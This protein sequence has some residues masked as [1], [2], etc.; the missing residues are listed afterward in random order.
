MDVQ[1]RLKT[2]LSSLSSHILEDAVETE[3]ISRGA[4]SSDVTIRWQG[5]ELS[6]KKLHDLPL[7]LEKKKGEDILSRLKKHCELLTELQHPN[8]VHYIGLTLSPNDAAPIL[9]N[10]YLPASVA[11]LLKS[12][13]RFPFDVQL[14]I[15]RDVSQGLTFLHCR[16]RPIVHANLNSDVVLLTRGLQAKISDLGVAAI[17]EAPS[18]SSKLTVSLSK[19]PEL[20]AFLPPDDGGKEPTFVTPS[21][22]VFAYGNLALHVTTGKWPIPAG[23][24][25][26]MKELDRRK[27]YIDSLPHNHCLLSLIQDCLQNDPLKRPNALS[28][29]ERLNRLTS[30]YPLSF[31]TA[32]ELMIIMERREGELV[33]MVDQLKAG[34]EEVAGIGKRLSTYDL[35][36]AAVKEQMKTMEESFVCGLN[37][38]KTEVVVAKSLLKPPNDTVRLSVPEKV[39]TCM[40]V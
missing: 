2:L 15:L 8:I 21:G 14:S 32:L 28:L 7:R 23:E 34:Q 35:E 33:S 26:T 29:V 4:Y 30:Q 17:L 10:E 18:N 3:E 31:Q 36:L 6:G 22:D 37:E 13:T 1:K 39:S 25:K 27:A 40:T 12:H 19:A 5:T 16:H 20:A 11:V 24:S 9:I 38:D